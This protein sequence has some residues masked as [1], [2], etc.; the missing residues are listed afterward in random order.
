MSWIRSA[1]L[2]D[3][4]HEMT[5]DVEFV[6][7]QD[8]VRRPALDHS[9]VGR[10]HIAADAV[11]RRRALWTKEIKE[12]FEGRLAATLAAPKQ[13]LARQVVHVGHV[14]VPLLA[15]DLIDADMG[16]GREV[17]VRQPVR[18]GG[19]D[20]ALHRAPGTPEQPGDL[21]PRQHPRPRRD[22]DQQG[23]GELLLADRPG[24]RL[25]THRATVPTRNPPRRIDQRH[26]NP[27]QRD[28][29][30]VAHPPCVPIPAPVLAPTAA[31]RIPPVRSQLR[32]R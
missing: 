12:R 18:H 28:M 24:Q 15:R 23:S 25:D 6:E 11:Q 20:R 5:H 22:R 10:P 19:L 29:A 32:C 7:D 17:A 4:L 1:D 14:D 9:H 26:G 2:V 21:L 3:G 30:K 27:P 31:R 16:H 13:P 8:R